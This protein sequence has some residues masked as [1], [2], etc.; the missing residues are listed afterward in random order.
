MQN[1]VLQREK[2]PKEINFS[3]SK[4]ERYTDILTLLC[5]VLGVYLLI[6]C[7]TGESLFQAATYNSYVLQANRWLSGYL[8]LGQ[9]YSHLEIA[10]FGGKFFVS[11]PPVPSIILLPFC[12]LF[13]GNPPDTLISV[14]IGLTGAL[15]ALKMMWITGRKGGW[16]VFWA[17]FF[18]VGSNFLHIGYSADVWYFAQTASF[19]FTLIALYHAMTRDLS[20]GWIPLF[21]LAL[22]FGCRP[23]QIVF[24]PLITFLLYRKFRKN[25]LS[26]IQSVKKYWWWVIP[27]LC[28]G[29]LLMGLNYARFGNVFQFGH[30]YLPEFAEEKPEG[31]F[32]AAY[33]GENWRKLWALPAVE[34]GIVRF[35]IFNGCA[36]WIFSPVFLIFTVY[37][38]KNLRCAVR[39]PE[40]LLAVALIFLQFFL[41]CFHATMGGWQFGNRYTVDALPV[42]LFALTVL[43]KEDSS[44]LKIISVPLFLWGTG[45]NLVGTIALL[46]GWLG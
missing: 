45:V 7:F 11:F 4:K 37:F 20:D 9:N 38:V 28:V 27:P 15:Y 18:T 14:S 41:T 44:D 5:G 8:D 16:A 25:N 24:L 42:L 40:L 39:K 6:W 26:I 17:L 30:D 22:A 46:N 13:G 2:I 21:F 29:I 3:I 32:S 34:A 33:L 31:Q 35:P 19:T 23:L 36:F 12:F 10:E 43:Q 1:G